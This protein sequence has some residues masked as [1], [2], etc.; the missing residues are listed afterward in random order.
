MY[1]V[2][3]ELLLQLGHFMLHPHELLKLG[4]ALEEQHSGKMTLPRDIYGDRIQRH[5]STVFDETQFGAIAVSSA[6]SYFTELLFEWCRK[7]FCW[8]PSCKDA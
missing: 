7:G 5:L 4:M 8:L 3:S 6:E 2:I 1:G